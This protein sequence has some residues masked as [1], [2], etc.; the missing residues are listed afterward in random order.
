[1]SIYFFLFFFPC[2]LTHSFRAFQVDAI[3]RNRKAR[4]RSNQQLPCL[5]PATASVYPN[6]P[7]ILDRLPTFY[8]RRIVRVFVRDFQPR[9]V[10]VTKVVNQNI[11]GIAIQSPPALQPIKKYFVSPV[12]VR[13]LSRCY[14]FRSSSM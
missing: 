5:I 13:F 3:D 8:L 1:M 2:N 12:S 6:V 11:E 9:L 10:S 7:S 4:Q 14:N